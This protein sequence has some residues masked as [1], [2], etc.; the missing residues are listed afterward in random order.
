MDF[1]LN[2]D[3]VL[4]RDTFRDF[5]Q[6]RIKPIAAELDESERFPEEL[7]PQMAEIG[8]FGIPIAEEYGGTGL[9]NI[10]YVMAVEEISK[11]C[12]STGVTISAHT[13]LCC[14]PIEKYGTTEQ[15]AKYLPKLASG[16]SLGAFG[17]TE[18]AAGPDAAM[19]QSTAE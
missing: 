3:Q 9:S 5:A 12:A 18:P 2:E 4:M 11:V 17:L 14:W 15:K 7:I 13:S 8:L 16:E 10:E 6:K 1:I 19:Q